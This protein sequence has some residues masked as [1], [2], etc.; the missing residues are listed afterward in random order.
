LE[1]MK[2]YTFNY[3]VEK[4]R[5]QKQTISQLLKIVASMNQ[6]MTAL[7]NKQKE[8]RYTLT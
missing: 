8:N 4:S 6:R 2:V 5:Q 1:K 3:L 7:E